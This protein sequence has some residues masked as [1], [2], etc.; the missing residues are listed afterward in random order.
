MKTYGKHISELAPLK[1]F[2]QDVFTAEAQYP[3]HLCEFML[4]LS[5]A[6]N[7][8][9]DLLLAHEFLNG[10]WPADETT[11]SP[12]LGE[13]NGFTNH[14]F[15]L[16]LGTLHELL[17][18]IEENSKAL[19]EPA[20]AAVIGKMSTKAQ[21][22]WAVIVGV[23][24]RT[25]QTKSDLI[26][27]LLFARNKV[28]FHYDGKEIGAGYKL[29]F[30]KTGRVPYVSRGA[31]L[32]RSRLYFADAAA[33]DYLRKKANDLGAP[34]AILTAMKLMGTVTFAIHQVV[35]TFI[36]TRAKLAA[37]PG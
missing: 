31:T 9:H 10:V 8:L 18:L 1:T 22:S 37:P 16:H 15:R 35:F 21:K 4:S 14:L 7:D 5:L 23:A 12:K 27:F 24:T 29:A 17:K 34:D 26:Q 32:G 25:T 19:K 36:T 2:Q 13:F 20:L 30:A 28:A 33:Q 6:F 11:P 3:R